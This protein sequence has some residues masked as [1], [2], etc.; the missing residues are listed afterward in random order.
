VPY[1]AAALAR[2]D[3]GW[4]GTELDLAG[5]ADLDALTDAL[6]EIAGEG[7]EVLA[8]CF[9]EEDDEWLGIVRVDAA[10]E[11]KVFISD[12]RVVEES[13]IGALLYQVPETESP[14]TPGDDEQ[15]RRL[16]PEPA[17]DL[18]LLEDLG[19][20]GAELEELCA[21]EGQLPADVITAIC[22]RAGCLE[23]LE[24]TRGTT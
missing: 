22:E 13:R 11:P 16:T 5:M 18:D 14:G 6:R 7:P 19:V 17:G 1:F 24:G 2:T 12:R 15:A 20:P 10:L 9:V 8:L 21:E 4:A 23:A 3:A